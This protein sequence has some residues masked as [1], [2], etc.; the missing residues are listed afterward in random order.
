MVPPA[1]I[2]ELHMDPPNP[3]PYL[4]AHQLLDALTPEAID[5]V[6][7]AVGPGSGSPLVSYELRHCGGALAREED[8]HG[9]LASL[10]GAFLSFG[11]GM[12]F[13]EESWVATR[14]RLDLVASALAD[15]D[16]GRRYFN[17]AEQAGSGGVL[18]AS[19]LGAPAGGQGGGRS[20]P[21]LP[22][23]PRDRS[24]SL[25]RRS[26]SRESPTV[27]M[28]PPPSGACT[29]LRD[30]RLRESPMLRPCAC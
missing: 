15:Y 20:R 11:V 26:P 4:G 18:H 6:V 10:P 9:A 5:A 17:F 2:A 21:A 7:A 29:S 27:C 22:G 12:I 14:A 1:G 13:G 28:P 3:I 24:S 8:G 30:H 23:E 25:S 19:H 16:T